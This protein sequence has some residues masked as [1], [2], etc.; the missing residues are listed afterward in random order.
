MLSCEGV[1]KSSTYFKSNSSYLVSSLLSIRCCSNQQTAVLEDV[2][3]LFGPPLE[4][5]LGEK[6]AE[7]SC[8][9]FLFVLYYVC[10]CIYFTEYACVDGSQWYIGSSFLKTLLLSHG[11]SAKPYLAVITRPLFLEFSLLLSAL[12][13]IT[14]PSG[15]LISCVLA[16]SV[17]L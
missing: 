11:L 10:L 12:S 5:A 15:V 3:A 6:K 14:L 7:G 8:S 4:S 9:S 1:L 16:P 13:T 2:T 17:F